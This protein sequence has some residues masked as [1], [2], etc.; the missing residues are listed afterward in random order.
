MGWQLPH[1]LVRLQLL[2]LKRCLV[3]QERT[4]LP[5]A[6]VLPAGLDAAAYAQRCAELVAIAGRR[7][8]ISATCLPQSLVLHALLQRAGLRPVLRLGV[9]PR[10]EPLHAHAWVELQGQA[11][12]NTGHA[13]FSAFPGVSAP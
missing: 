7:G 11:L 8:V 4:A 6:A 5:D 3:L 13:G 2:G 12:G 1:A 9:V 10:S